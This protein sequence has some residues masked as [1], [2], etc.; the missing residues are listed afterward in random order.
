MKT[1]TFATG[2]LAVV[3]ALYGCSPLAFAS[4]S[5]TAL[6]AAHISSRVSKAVAAAK[7]AQRSLSAAGS[8]SHNQAVLIR[9]WLRD[10]ATANHKAIIGEQRVLMAAGMQSGSGNASPTLGTPN[11]PPIGRLIRGVAAAIR[12]LRGAPSVGKAPGARAFATA[13]NRL[14]HLADVINSKFP[15]N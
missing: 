15:G 3:F 12:S 1:R 4:T 7:K 2:A 9:H 11:A 13:S 14:L 5:G 10:I 8:I 6:D